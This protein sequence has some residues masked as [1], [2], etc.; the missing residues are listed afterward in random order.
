MFAAAG[1]GDRFARGLVDDALEM[2]AVA[3]SAVFAV[4]RPQVIV[5][6][7]GIMADGSLLPGLRSRVEARLRPDVPDV[8]E[9]IQAAVHGERS[10]LEGAR[11]IARGEPTAVR[12]GASLGW[13]VRDD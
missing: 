10:V 4:L 11:A 6:G 1:A 12:M 8:E 2:L 9:L 7:G 5:M 13:G 3:I